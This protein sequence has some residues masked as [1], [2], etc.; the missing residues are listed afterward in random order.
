MTPVIVLAAGLSSRYHGGHKLLARF[1]GQPLIAHVVA[2]LRP[3]TR[4]VIVVTGYRAARVRS[5]LQQRFGGAAKLRFVHNRGYRNGMA[6][7]LRQGV[8]GLPNGVS[9]AFLCLGDMPGV[10]ARLLQRL[11][12]AWRPGLDYVRPVCR[13]RP[14][15]PVLVSVRLFAA[16][17]SLAGDQGAKAVLA[18][19]PTQRGKQLPWHDG[20]IIDTDTPALL[21]RAEL[22]LGAIKANFGAG[23]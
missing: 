13:R 2:Q 10:D 7:S 19:V 20:C 18:R 8:R 14:G 1:G 17:A 21:R 15:H 9:K 23:Q 5:C 16:F 3:A 12:A 11:E 4:P 22:R 6:G